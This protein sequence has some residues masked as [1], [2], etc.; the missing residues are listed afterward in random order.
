MANS[1]KILLPK[2]DA[3]NNKNDINIIIMMMPDMEYL[4]AKN[5]L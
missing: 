4:V 1:F 2:I 3:I 5:I